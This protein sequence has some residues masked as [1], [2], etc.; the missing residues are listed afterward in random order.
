MRGHQPHDKGGIILEGKFMDISQK[1]G[2]VNEVK[3]RVNSDLKE[4]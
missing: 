3:S 1:K 4:I 2:K